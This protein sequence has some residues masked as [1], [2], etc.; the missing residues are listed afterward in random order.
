MCDFRR[1]LAAT[2]AVALVTIAG[3]AGDRQG[4]VCSEIQYRLDTQTYSPDQRAYIEEELRVCR[5]DE[6]AKRKGDA[7]TRQS[8]YER[9]AAS[10]S[11]ASSANPS[12][13]PRDV[14]VSEALKDSSGETTT[15]IYDR[16]KAVGPADSSTVKS[17]SP[18]APAAATPAI[19]APADTSAAT[20]DTSAAPAESF[21]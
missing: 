9:Y 4:L 21:Q 17:D 14:S 16:Y 7:A 6:A 12:D 5:E 19:E 1:I 11:A 20:A 8:I 2:A 10:D 3:C 15:S 18:A 13:E